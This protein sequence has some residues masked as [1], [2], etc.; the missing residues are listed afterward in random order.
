MEDD[1][2]ILY[3]AY[4]ILYTSNQIAYVRTGGRGGGQGHSVRV[5][6]TGGGGQILAQFCIRTLWMAPRVTVD[7]WTKHKICG[8]DMRVR[9]LEK[10]T[11]NDVYT[12][13]VNYYM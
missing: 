1:L 11:R 6:Y 4:Y 2:L 5:A 7:A 3:Y 13:F 12:A 9:M 8:N 10:M